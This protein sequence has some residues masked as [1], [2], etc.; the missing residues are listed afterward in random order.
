MLIAGK[1]EKGLRAENEVCEEN[2]EKFQQELE[3]FVAA[4]REFQEA[5]KA[6]A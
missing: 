5:N 6:K 2:I 3:N 1:V 4:I